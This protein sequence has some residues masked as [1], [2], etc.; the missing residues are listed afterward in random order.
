TGKQTIK[1]PCSE[2]QF[3]S[4][5][6]SWIQRYSPCKKRYT[7]IFKGQSAD[8]TIATILQDTEWNFQ[9]AP[10]MKI[11]WYTETIIDAHQ[12]TIFTGFI[13]IKFQINTISYQVQ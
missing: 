8:A 12:N 1:I 5:F 3:I 6:G 7:C 2:S 10:E 11:E 13:I 9:K 4:I